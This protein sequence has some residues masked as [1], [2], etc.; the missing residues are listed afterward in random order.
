MFCR[1]WLNFHRCRW[2]WSVMVLDNFQILI[3]SLHQLMWSL[4]SGFLNLL[5]N[6][7]LFFSNCSAQWIPGEWNNLIWLLHLPNCCSKNCCLDSLRDFHYDCFETFLLS[8]QP[9]LGNQNF[10]FII[11]VF[12]QIFYN[13]PKCP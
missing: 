8:T 5:Q 2:Y 11:C 10:G 1:L 3:L 7:V 12:L 6:H 13:K 4:V 9:A